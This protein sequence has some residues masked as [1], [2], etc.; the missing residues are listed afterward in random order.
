MTHT[1]AL[2]TVAAALTLALTPL[3]AQAND[4]LLQ[5]EL[6]L[7]AGVAPAYEGAQKY[8]TGPAIS[9]GLSALDWWVFNLDKGDGMGFSF[10]PSFRYLAERDDKDYKRLAGI[11]DVDAA[12]ELGAK[13]AYRM[14][15][16]EVFGAVRMGVTGHDGVV[17]DVGVDAI[18][19]PASG[20]EFR[21]GPRITMA[22]DAYADTYFTVPTGAFLPAYDADGGLHSYGI[23]MSLRH[24]FNDQWA[25][26]GT[27]GWTQLAGSIG[28]SP[29][30]Q[31][32][33]AGTISVVVLRKFDWRW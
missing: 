24:D 6:G 26:K 9:G 20:T 8:T 28:D 18:L 27:V 30:V 13:L 32:R 5:F 22:S 31:E 2:T 17:M 15:N 16:S 23:E 7:G 14:P 10:G 4:N 21:V 1:T 25:I 29:V 3:S 11:D 19:F 12:L 33:N